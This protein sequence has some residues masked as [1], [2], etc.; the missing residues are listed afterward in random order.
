MASAQLMKV[1]NTIDKRVEGIADNVLVV[2]SRVA[3]I[4]ESVAGVDKRVAG[5]DERVAGVDERVIRVDDRVALVDDRVKDVDD[6]V[7]AVDD[8]LVAA[9]DGAQYTFNYSSKIFQSLTRLDGNEARG[10]IQQTA[11]DVDQVKRSWFLN[12]LHA[13]HVGSTILIGNQ[14]RQDL[15]RWLSPPDPSTNHNIACNTHHKGTTTWF[16]EGETYKDWKSTGSESLLWIHG[17]R[18]PRPIHSLDAT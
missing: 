5:V 16:F 18:V 3:G 17:K 11:D 10:V 7:K 8:R 6:K 14:L 13:R 4:D 1:T 15:R 2:D 9:I 12:R